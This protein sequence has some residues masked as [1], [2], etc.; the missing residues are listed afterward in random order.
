VED[1]PLVAQ[2]V[3]M[4]FKGFGFHG[5]ILL[6]DC[7]ESTL[8][9]LGESARVSRPIDLIVVDMQ[10][11]DGTGLDVVRKV[12]GDPFWRLTPILVLSG[13][14]RP[15]TVNEAYALGAN[16]YIPKSVK[17][18]LQSLRALYDC[19]VG[20]A[21]LPQNRSGDRIERIVD[22]A[23]NLRAR[24]SGFYLRLAEL[25]PD[26]PEEAHFWLERSL[27]E[28]NLSNLLALFRGKIGEKDVAAGAIE[29]ISGMQMRVEESLR[30]AEKRLDTGVADTEQVCRWVLD[31]VE[32]VD[33]E[34]YARSLG[35]LF[36]KG[37]VATMALK[38]RAV[39]QFDDLASFILERT[40]A[41]DLR[42]R[43]EGLRNRAGTIA[44]SLREEQGQDKAA[45]G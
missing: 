32:P 34:I 14:V 7:V 40:E 27:S 38:E 26:K 22:N 1:D 18:I 5:T 24:T 37:P 45:A 41:P 4:A 15:G 35:Y 9:L 16:C 3:A 12:R 28:G 44:A 42:R 17:P 43:G 2:L 13:E 30:T 19:W 25:F 6:T 39:A 33:G 8:V 31:V 11:P 23:V 29:S 20:S 21:L 36:P 10:L